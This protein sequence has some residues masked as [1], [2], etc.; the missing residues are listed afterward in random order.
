MS[1]SGIVMAYSTLVIQTIISL[2]SSNSEIENVSSLIPRD[3]IV[4]FITSYLSDGLDFISN[5]ILNINVKLLPLDKC[6]DAISTYVQKYKKASLLLQGNALSFVSDK[7]IVE[8]ARTFYLERGVILYRQGRSEKVIQTIHGKLKYER[9]LLA[10]RDPSHFDSI[11]VSGR[12]TVCPLDNILGVNNLPN[13]M[14]IQTMSLC[15]YVAQGANSYKDAEKTL[16]S[17][18]NINVDAD[19]IRRVSMELGKIQF[20]I[21]VKEAEE[22]DRLRR[23]N[24]LEPG[25]PVHDIV[26][27]MADGSHVP[28]RYLD[29]LKNVYNVYKEAKLALIFTESNIIRWTSKKGKPMHRI[30]NCYAVPYVGNAEQFSKLLFAVLYILGYLNYDEIVMVADGADWLETFRRVYIPKALRILDKFHLI[31]NIW[32]YAKGLYPNNEQRQQNFT[33]TIMSRIYQRNIPAALQYIVFCN[34]TLKKPNDDCVDLFSYISKNK[35]SIDYPTYEAKGLFVGSGAIE[36][37]NKSFVQQRL[38][39]PG[40][41]WYVDSA[42]YMLTLRRMAYNEKWSELEKNIRD[43][44]AWDNQIFIV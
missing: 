1:I 8:T 3:H 20:D 23:I 19:T 10:V 2:A 42:N 25:K 43:Y 29:E 18:L 39:E 7:Q 21:F 44:Y 27:V 13:K 35:D 36:S 26:Y 33:D 16:K 41:R 5:L 37:L 22:I 31:E 28:T 9:T 4:K 6:E 30:K 40:M 34:P 38:K 11:S 15:A 14:S 12:R 24:K 32:K 17:Y